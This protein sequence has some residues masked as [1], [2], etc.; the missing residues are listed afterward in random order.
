MARM[1]R[2]QKGTNPPSVG[3]GGSKVKKKWINPTQRGYT[4]SKGFG[5]AWGKIRRSTRHCSQKRRRVHY[6]MESRSGIGPHRRREAQKRGLMKLS[7]TVSPFFHFAERIY[8]LVCFTI[9][10]YELVYIICTISLDLL[11]HITIM[12]WRSL[13]LHHFITVFH[14][15]TMWTCVYSLHHWKIFVLP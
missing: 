8:P 6:L 11:H 5:A 3:S 15:F 4:A 1:R 7:I 2:L 14:H 12:R 9:L 10:P 13:L